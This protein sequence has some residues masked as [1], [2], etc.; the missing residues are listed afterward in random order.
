MQNHINYK[1][2]AIEER[3]IWPLED[4]KNYLRVSHKNDDKLIGSLI[5]SAIDYAE[6]FLRT[7]FFTKKIICTIDSAPSYVR[8]K[9]KPILRL[10]KVYLI[11][12]ENKEDITND[13]GHIDIDQEKI[14]I[15]AKY[16]HDSI[17]IIY[18]AGLG[19]NIPST[20]LQGILMHIGNMYDAPESIATLAP[21]IRDM[22]LPYR[23]F[24]V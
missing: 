18:E 24:R 5:K 20:I 10:D 14:W 8:V 17:V 3:E 19:A 21:E 12:G 7:G 23:S 15:E 1:I 11:N 16:W 4:V 13:F 2:T 6:Q 9:Y 22:Y